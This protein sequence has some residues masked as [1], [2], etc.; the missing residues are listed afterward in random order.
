MVNSIFNKDNRI[1]FNAESHT[2]WNGEDQLRSVT[3]LLNAVTKPFDRE[4]ISRHIA[5]SEAKQTGEDPN[6][7]Q[8]RTLDEW[9]EKRKSS[10][11][12]GNFIH[13]N[14]ESYVTKGK[15]SP[16]LQGVVEQIFPIIKEG[17][18]AYPEALL[19]SIR[20]GTAGM[21]DLAIQRQ[22]TPNSV[23]DFWDYKTN[24][25]K[26]IEYD[27]VSRKKDPEKHYNR[28]LLPPFNHLEDCNYN[29]Y[30]LQLSAYAFMAKDTW[31]LRIG[32]LGILFVDLNMKV[33]KIP[34]PFMAKEA[35]MLL[36]I[37]K[38][39]KQL[40]KTDH[41]HNDQFIPFSNDENW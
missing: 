35:E 13:D 25:A 28:F 10:E 36:S 41:V 32:R 30:A 22:R 26:G 15:Y 4:G 31:N 16:K 5:Q 27:S 17:Y 40:P 34:V 9:E 20:F 12:R 7:I 2:Y 11:D 39:L 33:H 14:L 23:F 38:E 29:R 37:S 8:M 18:R 19:Y 1:S 6:V 24:E 21:T 3:R